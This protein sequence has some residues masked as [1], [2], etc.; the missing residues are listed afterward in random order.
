MYLLDTCV[1]SDARRRVPAVRA[2]LGTVS[3]ASLFLSVVTVG[4][5]TKGITLRSRQDPVAAASLQNWLNNLRDAHD[6]RILPIDEAIAIAWGQMMAARTLPI[7][8][9]LIAATA[10]AHALVLVTRNVADF[11]GTGVEIVNPWVNA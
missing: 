2:W 5:M 7:A 10:R 11:A 9:A 4:E 6:E 3:P 8:D 1:W